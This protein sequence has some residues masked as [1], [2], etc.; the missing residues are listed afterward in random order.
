MQFDEKG[1]HRLYAVDL[2][3]VLT[4]GEPFWEVEPTP[5]I[6]AIVALRE[7]YKKGNII[8]IWTAR[9]WTCAQETVAWLFKYSVPMHGL[10]MAKGG[11]DYY[12]DDKAVLLADFMGVTGHVPS[13]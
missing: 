11:A 13:N 9:Q 3:G 12:V 1:P 5:N 10:Y 6:E 7:L 2:D 4:N 8:V